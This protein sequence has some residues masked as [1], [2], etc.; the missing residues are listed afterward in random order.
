MT[1]ARPPGA[2]RLVLMGAPGD[3]RNLGVSALQR[4]ALAAIFRRIPEAEVT[5]FDNGLGVRHETVQVGREQRDHRCVGA[6]LSRRWYRP[7]SL[8]NIR[9][10]LALG[11]LANP[12]ARAL[13]RADAVLDV[14]GG[15]SFSDLYGQRRFEAVAR[16]KEMAL[17]RSRALVLLPQTYGPFESEA[18]AERARSVVRASALALARDAESHETLLALC[19]GGEGRDN[20]DHCRAGVDLA[21]EL[22]ATPPVDT[23][24]VDS[25][26]DA[27]LVGLNVS[28]LV[29]NDPQAAVRFGF[30]AAYRDVVRQLIDRL[31]TDAGARVVLVA[32]VLAPIDTDESD[33]RACQSV[34]DTF[35]GHD[36]HDRLVVAQ[37]IDD[38][39]STKGLISRFDWFC[40]TRMHSTIAALSSGVPAASIA[41]SGKAAGVFAT[42]DQGSHV[43]DLRRLTTTEV[44]DLVWRSWLDRDRAR[45]SLAKRLPTILAR[46]RTQMD[47]VLQVALDPGARPPRSTRSSDRGG[48]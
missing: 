1:S 3:T 21:F 46:A 43:A 44:V 48:R 39:S 16:P 33:P 18:N 40:G 36:R 27:P 45:D 4:S 19:R 20:A 30:R 14:S 12:T 34:A 11:G 42:C 9:T 26:D 31:L 38:P 41:Y 23:S 47:D 28:G 6:R 29:Y 5:V 7:E 24:A 22:E 8:A 35:A 17:R 10:S 2:P 25:W 37:P 15:D 32:H 13:L